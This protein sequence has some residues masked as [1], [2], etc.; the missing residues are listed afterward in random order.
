MSFELERESIR[1]YEPLKAANVK[2][3][4]D[5]DI[6][7][8]DTKP[9][10]LNILEVN[11]MSSISEKHVQKD[12]IR[13]LGNV[14]YT[15]LYSGGDEAIEIK[16]IKYKVPFTEEIAVEG[17]DDGMYN[18]VISS[19]SHV[20]SKIQNSRKINIKSVVSFD[21]CAA[22]RKLANSV[23]A[24]E[25]SIKL[26]QKR[27]NINVL[28]MTVCSESTFFVSDEL[29]FSETSAAVDEILKN[30]VSLES[31]EVKTM[32]NKVVVKGSV[33]TNTLYT[34]D[35]ELYHVKNET[36]FTE[37]IDAEGLTPEMHTEIKYNVHSAEYEL[38]SDDSSYYIGFTGSIDVLIKAYEE[39]SYNII[40]DAYCPDFETEIMRE[41]HAVRNV[42]ESFKE[43][44]ATN[45]TV[46]LAESMPGIVKVYNLIVN[47]NID[48]V[49]AMDGYAMIDGYLDAKILYLS[50]STSFPVY[51]ANK[52][53]PFSLR[54]NNKRITPDS[55]IDTE[56]C[57]EHSSY[58]LK[59]ESDIE[60]RTALKAEGKIIS[61]SPIELISDISIKE[62][63]PL[64]KEN[65]PGIVI[66]FADENEELWDIAKR[67]HTTT[68]ELAAINS[69]EE[70]AVLSK[71]QQL[72]IP[73]R[74]VI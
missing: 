8:P 50:D 31:R 6:I 38:N 52:K 64:K 19:I 60:V 14:D 26:P 7:V 3:V 39:N 12:K 32:N 33:I 21:T 49:A 13:V 2:A 5:T 27:D 25:S 4:V 63:M 18:Y 61:Q 36:P 44:F 62:D 28:D 70:D 74:L 51:A 48:S 15:V 42:D 23:C 11:A 41:I 66:Y 54:L 47:P 29:K 72:V 71:R 35:G 10:V 73:K 22:S 37:V 67:Y 59:S 20:E 30:D 57:L 58:V 16:S 56:V 45:E 68:D 65:Q 40:T 34:S 53:I 17:I 46:S 1:I 9:D 69:I 24:V 55:L 43:S